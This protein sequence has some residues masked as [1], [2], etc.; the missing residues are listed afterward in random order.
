MR[1]PQRLGLGTKDR[2]YIESPDL[3]RIELAGILS[4]T[5]SVERSHTQISEVEAPTND[6]TEDDV[7]EEA[8]RELIAL[9]LGTEETGIEQDEPVSQV[10]TTTNVASVA[11]TSVP[12]PVSSQRAA[13][14]VRGQVGPAAARSGGG[15]ISASARLAKRA[16]Q[17]R[18]HAEWLLAEARAEQ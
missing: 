16:A 4:G 15:A 10:A 3:R 6:S 14:Q 17:D 13:I 18:Q 2:P 9:Q 12:Q 1:S 7:F 11:Y 8:T 5:E